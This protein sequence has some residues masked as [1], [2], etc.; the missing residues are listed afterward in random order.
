M[1]SNLVYTAVDDSYQG[2]RMDEEISAGFMKELMEW[3]RKEKKLHRKYAYKV[4]L[5]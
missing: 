5:E 4:S 1:C 2:P 3:L